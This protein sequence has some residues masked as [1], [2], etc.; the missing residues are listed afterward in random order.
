MLRITKKVNDGQ[1]LITADEAIK[2]GSS[3]LEEANCEK[4]TPVLK[5]IEMQRAIDNK[6]IR[7]VALQIAGGGK[8]VAL[9]DC[10]DV[11]VNPTAITGEST[12]ITDKK[13][14]K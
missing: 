7:P 14:K 9:Y 11:G 8:T 3:F 6:K 12:A 1:Y 13:E 10:L 5:A 2:Y 4:G